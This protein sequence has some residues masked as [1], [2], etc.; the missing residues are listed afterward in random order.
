MDNGDYHFPAATLRYLRERTP[1]GSRNCTLFDAACQLRDMGRPIGEAEQLFTALKK[2]G[3]EVVLVR[4]PNETHDLSR[5]GQPQHRIERLRLI[6]DWFATH[7]PPVAL[8]ARA[9]ERLAGAPA[10][11]A[12]AD[13]GV[14]I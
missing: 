2:Q 14:E 12:G 4:F 6:V 1:K 7:I 8:P 9:E 5:N 3:K 11:D 10:G 13:A